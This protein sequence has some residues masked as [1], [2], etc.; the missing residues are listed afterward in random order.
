M[1][2]MLLIVNPVAG[3]KKAAKHLSEIIEVFNRAE[4]EVHVYITAQQKNT[5]K[6]A[7]LLNGQL[8]LVVCCGGDG[9]LNETVNIMLQ[10][11]RSI[12]I[13][14]IPAG[15][16]NDFASTL[17]LPGDVVAA[18]K[19]IVNGTPQPYDVGKFLD[20][21]FTYVASFGAFTKASYATP[22]RVKN[23]LGHTAYILS[24]IQ[25]LSQLRTIH[26]RLELD[27]TVIE[28]DFLF[29]AISN[30]VSVGGVLNLDPKQVDMSD[31]KLELL[32]VRSPKTLAE[33]SE[34]IQALQ[35]QKYNCRM[36]TFLS[37]THVRVIGDPKISW[38]LDG[39][40]ADGQSV[41]DI[42]NIHH[43]VRLVQKG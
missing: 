6:V 31:G 16:T 35:T 10:T 19:Q 30:S 24:G 26:M 7:E 2:H 18:A 34:C 12:P 8:D 25:E 21:Y 29:G 38:T 27:D 9:T 23:A 20:R 41:V 22:Q 36:I 33:I 32:L 28:D 42:H 5:E 3:Q 14:Y 17:G 39:E 37:A 40:R 13:G 15:S 11:G 1:K 43:A 4:Y